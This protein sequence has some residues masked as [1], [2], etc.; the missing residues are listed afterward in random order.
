M[1]LLRK[2]RIPLI[3]IAVVIALALAW[4]LPKIPTPPPQS[5]FVAGSAA[6]DFTLKDQDGNPITLSALHGQKVLLYFYRGY[7]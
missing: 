2:L 7:W 3:V 5:A 6:P 1:A 4:M